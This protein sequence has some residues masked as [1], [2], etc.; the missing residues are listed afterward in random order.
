LSKV[1]R[2]TLR[3][4]TAIAVI[5]V[6]LRFVRLGSTP[7]YFADEILAAA[8]LRTFLGNGHHIRGGHA[9]ILAHVVPVLDGRLAISVLGTSVGDLRII[10]ALFG[11]GSI[12]LIYR[13]GTQLFD[14]RVGLGAGLVMTLMPWHI[15]YSRAFLPQS[16]YVFLTLAASSFLISALTQQRPWDGAFAVAAAIAS[17]YIYPSAL[18]S[19][20]LLM[21]LAIV[22]YH[23]EFLA[24][25][26]RRILS[27]GLVT[28]LALSPYLLDHLLAS[29]PVVAGQNSVILDKLIWT[30]GLPVTHML[31]RIASNWASYFSLSF[32]ATSGDPNIRQSTHFVGAIGWPFGFLA[33]VGLIVA[34]KRHTRASVLVVAWMVAF[35]LSSA[36][37]YSDAAGNSARA[38]FGCA[39]W[40]MVAGV[41]AAATFQFLSGKRLVLAVAAMSV[42]IGVQTSLFLSDYFFSY[43]QRSAYAFETGWDRVYEVLRRHGLE[44]VPI[45]LHAGYER[46]EIAQY[47]SDGRLNIAE[48][49]YSCER[50]PYRVAHYTVLP[51]VFIVRQDLDFSQRPECFHGDLIQADL[52]SLQTTADRQGNPQAVEVVASFPSDPRSRQRVAVL[53]IASNS[54]NSSNGSQ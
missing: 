21:L 47:Y 38:V 46:E 6:G 54:S 50:L 2:A 30:H 23:R 26:L 1:A 24:F 16:E 15:Y 28:G 11:L 7:H 25:G 5:A 45:T 41:G 17:I 27:L 20:P 32:I 52:G 9:G 3:G 33:L 22:A 48:I 31:S 34:C 8:D 12:A 13:I 35:P 19:T 53:F 42:T 36:I 44:N 4:E 10:A 51:R 43:P 37:T 14:R 18:L 29:D 49:V 39:A 40:A